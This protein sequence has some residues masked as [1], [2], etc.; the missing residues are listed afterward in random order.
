DGLVKFQGYDVV[1]LAQWVMLTAGM[2]GLSGKDSIAHILY[3]KNE[4]PHLYAQTYK[5]LEPKDY[6]NLKLTGLFATA[7]DAIALHWVT[8]NRDLNK[9]AYHPSLLKTLGVDKTKL[10]DLYFSTDVLGT[11]LP[12]AAVDLGLP[13]GIKVVLGT[14]DVQ[15]AALG[16][17]AVDDFAAH[18]YIGT[19]SWLT[20]HV[21][22][23]KTSAENNMA[24]I[25]SAIPGKYIIGNEQETAGYV[26]TYL[27]DKV[28]F[29]Q[30][31][32]TSQGAPADVYALFNE[33]ATSVPA[34]SDKLIFTPWLIGERTPIEDHT[35]RGGFFNMS[36]NTTRAHLVRA[37]FE[38]VAY[39][40]RWLLEAVEDFI[41][42]GVPFINMIGGGARSDLWCQIH[43]DV[44]NREIR[45]VADPIQANS[46]GVA[47]LAGVSLGRFRFSDI[48]SRVAI[49]NT[50]KPN[51]AN[52]KI[53]DEL[54][55][56]FKNVYEAHK[57][58]HARLNAT[59]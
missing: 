40:S 48:S 34:G 32:L 13:A 52:R 35:I 58:I 19:S 29:P 10:P 49:K 41:G 50:Y 17:G 51:A 56:E 47:L 16:S 24:T 31:A 7:Q 26:L 33:L 28:F 54:Y 9:V 8:D 23:K 3:I 2:P 46:R 15:S 42:R 18:L 55:G 12:D 37:A 27:R 45:Q 20:C 22:F 5:F 14:P 4:M 6:L 11:L 43:A 39:N 30:D 25:P 59:H 57:K 53:Y 36:L 21:P 38:G 1:K 44:L